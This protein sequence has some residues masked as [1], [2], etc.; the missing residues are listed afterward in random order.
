MLVGSKQVKLLPLMGVS[1]SAKQLKDNVACVP[2]GGA[3][4]LPQGCTILSSLLLVCLCIHSLPPLISRSLNLPFGAQVSLNNKWDTF[5]LKL[6]SVSQKFKLNLALPPGAL[7]QQTPRK[8]PP[9]GSYPRG[10]QEVSVHLS[11]RLTAIR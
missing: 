5:I 2:R 3:K 7:G 9:P 4:A 6:F 10:A 8:P 1:V 11:P